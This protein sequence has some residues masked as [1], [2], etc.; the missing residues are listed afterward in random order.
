MGKHSFIPR[1]IRKMRSLFRKL[2]IRVFPGEKG[3]YLI[4]YLTYRYFHK[5]NFSVSKNCDYYQLKFDNGV[6]LKTFYPFFWDFEFALVG[7]LDKYTPTKGDFI[8]DA[9]AFVGHFALYLSKLIGKE[10]KIIA[11]EPDPIVFER[12]T[13]NIALNDVDNI[14]PIQFGLWDSKSN[15]KFEQKDYGYSTF[16]SDSDPN[17]PKGGDQILLEVDTLPNIL[18]SFE[19]EV[20]SVD[21]LKMDIEGAEIQALIGAESL[22]RSKAIKNLAI[23]SYHIVDGEKTYVWLTDYLNKFNY[24]TSTGFEEHLTTYAYVKNLL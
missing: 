8:I 24:T 20:E 5:A 18:S 3:E 1:T 14:I 9:G 17:A 13:R 12:L 2:L 21:F 11:L 4:R 16:V 10:A 23:A 19:I 15:L 22:L 6:E 7:Y